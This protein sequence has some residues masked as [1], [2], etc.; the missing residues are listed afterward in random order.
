MVSELKLSSDLSSSFRLFQARLFFTFFLDVQQM[1]NQS[2][3]DFNSNPSN[4]FFLNSNE[5]P[6]LVLVT[7]LMNGKNYHSW[8]RAM[9]L[10]LHSKNKV[11]FIDKSIPRP[12]K[13]H[14]LYSQWIRFNTMILSWLQHLVEDTIVKSILWIDDALDVWKDLHD[15]FSQGD[16][17]HISE[18]QE[19]FY[20][21]SQCSLSILEYFTRLKTLREELDNIKPTP[22][23]HCGN[24]CT[25]GKSCTCGVPESMNGHKGQDYVIRFLK[26]LNDQYA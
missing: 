12:P 20:R 5:N 8:S 13:G 2:Y 24:V 26:G 15:R 14:P 19:D 22:H 1:A 11:K 23:C 21:L 10:A 4:P 17:F 3:E 7:S 18:L 9:M 25:C 6:T 16:V